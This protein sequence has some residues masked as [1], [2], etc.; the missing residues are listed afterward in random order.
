[1]PL[2]EKAVPPPGL[3]VFSSNSTREPLL[4]ATSAAISPHPPAPMTMMSRSTFCMEPP[5]TR[6]RLSAGSCSF[7]EDP[8]NGLGSLQQTVILV[9]ETDELNADWQTGGSGKHGQCDARSIGPRRQDIE[10]GIARTGQSCRCLSESTGREQQ[11]YILQG[12]GEMPAALSQHG[13]GFAVL[14]VG[15]I[16]PSGKFVT[17]ELAQKVPMMVSFPGNGAGEL[18]IIDAPAHGLELF[19][20]L[21]EV[22][23][24]DLRSGLP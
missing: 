17:L 1:M 8:V 15:D 3:S 22:E 11:V 18:V 4:A 10:R 24:G 7:R 9:S 13:F 2:E 23:I 21:S 16:E 6:C 20:R 12:V 14:F 19:K 5:I